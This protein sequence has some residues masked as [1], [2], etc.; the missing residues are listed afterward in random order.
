VG[1]WVV[2]E[3]KKEKGGRERWTWNEIKRDKL[4]E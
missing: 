2:E 1:E 4:E 3:S